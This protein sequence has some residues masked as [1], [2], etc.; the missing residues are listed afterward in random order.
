MIGSKSLLQRFGIHNYYVMCW[1]KSQRSPNKVVVY[2]FLIL[3]LIGVSESQ[4]LVVGLGKNKNSS[5]LLE[6]YLHEPYAKHYMHINSV[7]PHNN[8]LNVI[9]SFIFK[10]EDW[11]IKGDVPKS[12]QLIDSRAGT[13][14]LVSKAILLTVLYN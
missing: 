1:G 3:S 4:G 6:T 10:W 2:T 13:Q 11:V 12:K 7:N 8:Q 9:A 14:A 5:Q